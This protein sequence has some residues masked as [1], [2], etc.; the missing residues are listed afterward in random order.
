MVA[1]L[2]VALGAVDEENVVAVDARQADEVIHLLVGNGEWGIRAVGVGAEV[3]VVVT[4]IGIGRGREG[5]VKSFLRSL[6]EEKIRDEWL[7]HAFFLTSNLLFGIMHGEIGVDG[8]CQ[9]LL[10]SPWPLARDGKPHAGQTIVSVAP[11]HNCPLLSKVHSLPTP[12]SC[13][14]WKSCEG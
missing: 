5:K 2:E 11:A 9:L 13:L 14:D 3:I 4:E 12:R 1:I 8:R 10:A 7:L 6:D